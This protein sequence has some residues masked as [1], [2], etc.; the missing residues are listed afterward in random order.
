M[1][2]TLVVLRGWG[3]NEYPSRAAVGVGGDECLPQPCRRGWGTLEGKWAEVERLRP[4]SNRGMTVLQTVALPLG[5]GA[6][7]QHV[8]SRLYPPRSLLAIPSF[9]LI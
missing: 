3:M 1:A 6:T 5:Y 9:I 7:I 4:D 2:S 8:L